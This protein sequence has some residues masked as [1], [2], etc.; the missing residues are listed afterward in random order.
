MV[1]RRARRNVDS[2]AVPG[3]RATAA[4]AGASAETTATARRLA[5][6]PIWHDRLGRWSIRSL[7]VMLVAALGAIAVWALVQVKLLVIPVLIAL[8]VAAAASPLIGWLRRFMSPILAA[9]V[10]LLGG[11][12]VLGGVVTAIVFAVR[13]QWSPLVQSASEGFDDLL[14]WIET[15]PFPIDRIQVEQARDSIVDFLTSAEFGRGALAGVSAAAEL[16]TGTL[17]LLVVLFFF[18]KDGDRIWAFFLR[19]YTGAH[20]ERGRRVGVTSVKVLGGYVRGTAIIALVDAVAI[21]VGLVILQVPLALPLAVIVFLGAFIPLIGA[22]VAGILAALVALVANGPI[23]ALIVVAIVIAV[24]QLEGDL[25]QPVVMAQ[26][27]KLHPLVI[28]IALTAGTIVGGIIG[29]VLAVPLT[30]VGWAIIK[31]WDGPDPTIDRRKPLWRRRRRV[32][33]ATTAG[34]ALPPD[35]AGGTPVA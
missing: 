29:A 9:W 23:V 17:L 20:L 19:P 16:I 28:L 10:T 13:N 30:A 34:T 12:I 11:I 33:D 18:L 1:F 2:R 5:G 3:L 14:A 26:S 6:D 21:G 4:D 27:L 24:N 31:V 22:T 25:L 15:L 7:Q 8:I 35:S 32:T